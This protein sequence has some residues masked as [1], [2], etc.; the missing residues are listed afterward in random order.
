MNFGQDNAKG[1]FRHYKNKNHAEGSE[2]TFRNHCSPE[3]NYWPIAR[4]IETFPYK[5]RTVQTIRLRLGDTVEAD[6]C[7][8][9]YEYKLVYIYK[10]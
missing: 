2:E 3:R 5:R 7:E 10:L 1:S 8:L 6:K 4:T 9:V